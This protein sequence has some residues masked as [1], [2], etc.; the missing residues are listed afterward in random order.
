MHSDCLNGGLFVL[1]LRRQ[2]MKFDGGDYL[3]IALSFKLLA[4]SSAKRRS[5]FDLNRLLLVDG[6]LLG[7]DDFE[8]VIDALE[9]LIFVRLHAVLHAIDEIFEL[10]MP[11]RREL[12]VV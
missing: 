4:F 1:V 9:C 12:F 11:A 5:V 2:M 7:H 3:R 8:G 10:M 6:F